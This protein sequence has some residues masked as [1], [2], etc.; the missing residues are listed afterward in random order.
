MRLLLLLPALALAAPSCEYR[1]IGETSFNQWNLAPLG[2][3]VNR[4]ICLDGGYLGN[5][6]CTGLSQGACFEQFKAV[7]EQDVRRAVENV[8]PVMSNDS[9]Q[10][11]VLDLEGSVRPDLFWSFSDTDL[12]AVVRG[13]KMRVAVLKSYFPG[14]TVWALWHGDPILQSDRELR[15]GNSKRPRQV[16]K[17]DQPGKGHERVR[18]GISTWA[19]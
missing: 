4:S 13:V 7:T 14:A 16:P 1:A 8:V 6:Q 18:E 15:P 2:I 17:R 12:A 9:T 3:K 19:L 5:P 10:Q 11:I